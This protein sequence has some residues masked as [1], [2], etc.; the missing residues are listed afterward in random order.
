M[1][2]VSTQGTATRFT[3]RRM[4]LEDL[5]QVVTIDQLSFSLPWPAHSYRYELLE[6]VVSRQWVAEIQSGEEASKVVGMIVVWLILDEAH[7]A[8]IAVHPQYRGRGIGQQMLL[9]A[10]R[11]CTNQGAASA[12]L[13]VREHNQIAIA[14]YSKL[15]F[16]IVGR[17]KRYYKD[18]NEDAVLMT[19]KDLGLESITSLI[20]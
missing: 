14:M 8:T 6:N 4:I 20:G 18:T 1:Q 5:E 19:L 7:I 13:E 3:V 9:T 15:G 11:E 16:E 10:L 12:T 2:S 17:R